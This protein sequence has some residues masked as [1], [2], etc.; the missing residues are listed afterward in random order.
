[1]TLK[2]DITIILL[3]FQFLEKVR[4]LKILRILF[5][6]KMLSY[7]CVKMPYVASSRAL[8]SKFV[9]NK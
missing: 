5:L 7:L 6:R 3:S 2:E 1:M 4:C 8:T 9:N